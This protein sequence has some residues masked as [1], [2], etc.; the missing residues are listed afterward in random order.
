M[1]PVARY[2]PVRKDSQKGSE[3]GANPVDP[4]RTREAA[5]DDSR[6]ER[7]SW[8]ERRCGSTV[9]WLSFSQA[10]ICRKTYHQ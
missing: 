6:A 2:L 5:I 7:T 4:V 9:S 3:Q 1:G 8:V 10:A